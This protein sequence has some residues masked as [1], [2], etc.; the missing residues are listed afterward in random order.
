MVKVTRQSWLQQW[1]EALREHKESGLTVI[2][3]CRLYS[4]SKYQFYYNGRK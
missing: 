2:E 4:V 3:W 1:A